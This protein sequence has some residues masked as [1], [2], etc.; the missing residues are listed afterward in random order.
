MKK[1]LTEFKLSSSSKFVKILLVGP[2][3]AGK[4]NFINSVNNVFQGRMTCAAFANAESSGASFTLKYKTHYTKSG[5]S[6]LPFV[7]S[8]TMG[9]EEAE[10]DGV[11]TDDLI[12]AL[13]DQV[14]EGYT[15]NPVSSLSLND[16]GFVNNPD[17]SKPT[18]CL[19]FVLPADKV[20]LMSFKVFEKLKRIRKEATKMEVPQVLLL[21]RVDKACQLVAKDLKKVYTSKKV[22]EQMEICHINLGIPMVHIFPVKNYHEEIDTQ[23]DIDVLILKALTQIVHLANDKFD[24]ANHPVD[25]L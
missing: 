9:L 20:K 25:T 22:K 7:F 23:N 24:D 2:I 14:K 8:D 12:K 4:S 6:K 17:R 11:R 16:P 19:V 1:A 3:G 13:Q 10:S 18:C 15:F 5:H 21:T